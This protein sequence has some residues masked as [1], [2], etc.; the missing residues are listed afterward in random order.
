MS[1]EVQ[2]TNRNILT[3]DFHGVRTGVSKG[4]IKCHILIFRDAIADTV[5][6]EHIM[7]H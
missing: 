4:L 7:S 2:G 3:V 1:A 6:V 5:C